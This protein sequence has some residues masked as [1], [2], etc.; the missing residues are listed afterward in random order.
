MKLHHQENSPPPPLQALQHLQSGLKLLL[1]AVLFTNKLPPQKES[2]S[3]KL[4][5]EFAKRIKHRCGVRSSSSLWSVII[6]MAD[7]NSCL[8]SWSMAQPCWREGSVLNNCSGLA[9]MLVGA[10]GASRAPVQGLPLPFLS[11][12]RNPM[13]YLSGWLNYS[14]LGTGLMAQNSALWEDPSWSG[15]EGQKMVL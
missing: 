14:I 2:Y 9:Q 8:C 15:F 12:A 13:S 1:L 6:T 11:Q 4:G 3:S 10:R 5:C 7:F